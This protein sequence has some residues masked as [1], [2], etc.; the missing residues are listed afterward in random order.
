V[1]GGGLE[2][3]FGVLFSAIF[4]GFSLGDFHQSGKQWKVVK[5]KLLQTAAH[6]RTVFVLVVSA[7]ALKSLVAFP[8]HNPRFDPFMVSG[9]AC[10]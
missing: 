1:L 4:Q 9:P 5:A 2:P 10:W 3:H 7:E 8:G 6:L